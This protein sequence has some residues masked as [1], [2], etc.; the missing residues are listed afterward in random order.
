MRVNQQAVHWIL[1]V[2]QMWKMVDISETTGP[3]T[4]KRYFSGVSERQT[5]FGAVFVKNGSLFR[6]I[7]PRF[8]KKSFPQ[9]MIREKP[10]FHFRV[11]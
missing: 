4:T 6:E 11:P 1:V 7:V 9:K 5:S 3:N 10:F 2:N 8:S